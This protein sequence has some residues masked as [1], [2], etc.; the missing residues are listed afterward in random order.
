M[1]MSKLYLPTLKEDPAE[2]EVTSHKLMLRAGLMRKHS[3]GIYSYLPLGYRIIKKIEKI[4]RKHMDN[5]GAQEVLL[6]VMQTSEIW[7]DS[8]RWDKFGP[9]MIKFLDRKNREYC[10]GPT[11]E[12]VVT[13]LVRDEVRSYKDLPLNLYQIQTKV[14]DEIRPR[15]GVMRGREF[16]MKDAYSLDVDYQG[17][18]KSYQAMYD[19]YE[20]IFAECGLEAVAVEADTGAMGGK[21]S[22]E[23]M[24][25][26]DSGEDEIAFCSH[27]DYAANVERATSDKVEIDFEV[28]SNFEK[29]HTPE[30]KTID[31]LVEY[32]EVPAAKMIK[33]VALV[34]D[35][36]AVLAL[37]SGE[38]E[39][40]EIKLINYLQAN[41]LRAA[42]EE[43]FEEL[44]NSVP[45]F[46]GPV[47]LDEVRVVAD[48]R[49]QNMS[50]AVVGANEIDYHFKDVKTGRDFEVEAFTDLRSVKE[51]ENCSKCESGKLNIKDGIEVGHIFKLGTK[52]SENMGA[53]YLDENGKAQPIVMGSYGIGIT[54]LVAAAIEQNNDQYGIKWPKAIAPYQVIILPLGN[55]RLVQE[56]S[57][58]IYQSLKDQGWEVLIDDRQERAGVKFNDSELIGIPLRLTIGSRSLENGV[59]EAM[60]RSTNEKLE[61]KL[62]NLEAKVKELFAEIS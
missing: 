41:E 9:L 18:D 22:H 15:F 4:T 62:D 59:V 56:K 57:E 12:E 6:P 25:L 52:Y 20:R 8:K 54:R 24:V 38:D 48:K 34:A 10:L 3:S 55:D 45:G 26:A 30:I 23:F 16:I 17:L 5:S 43:E 2:A 42:E 14:R 21:D 58:E 44:F 36:E 32:L 29:I 35:G 50:G 27:C 28:D 13:D 49:L 39:L 1:R 33:A 40:N 46:I 60:I 31:Q 37:V 51:G 19:A 11:H 47:N 7:K 53:N 61:I